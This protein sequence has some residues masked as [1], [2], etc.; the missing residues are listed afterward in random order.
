MVERAYHMA[1]TLA[2]R[3]TPIH[4]PP[5]HNL[6]RLF[7]HLLPRRDQPT[8]HLLIYRHFH[9]HLI[10]HSTL[11]KHH[12][13]LVVVLEEHGGGDVDVDFTY[14]SLSTI[15]QLVLFQSGDNLCYYYICDCGEDSD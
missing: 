10:Y 11:N 4:H 1:H 3:I 5:S 6:P 13:Y 9:L 12:Y 8:Q 7:H 15:H 2:T 14:R